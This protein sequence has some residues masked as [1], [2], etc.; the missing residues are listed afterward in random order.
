[1]EKAGCEAETDDPIR[2]LQ[3]RRAGL[4]R[5]ES[6]REG[7]SESTGENLRSARARQ[8]H[9]K[10]S[11]HRIDGKLRGER[12]DRSRTESAGSG[13]GCRIGGADA[14]LRRRERSRAV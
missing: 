6:L 12:D 1:P 11:G 8:R 3:R 4:E 14:A 2:T 9:W 10:S 13:G 7:A 5:F